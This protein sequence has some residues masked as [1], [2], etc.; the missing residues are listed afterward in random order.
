MEFLLPY[1]PTFL[2]VLLRTGIVLSLLPVLGS[3]SLPSSFKIGLAVAFA[4]VLTPVVQFDVTRQEIPFLVMREALFGIVLGSTARLT[5]LAVDMAGQ[6]ISSAM[7]LSIATVFNPEIGQ[8]TEVARFF[9]MIAILVFLSTDAHHDLIAVFARSYEIT[10]SH[11]LSVRRLIES[12]LFSG[13][14]LFG[15]ALKL[16]APVVVSMLIVNLLLGFLYKIAPQMNVFFVG[17]PVY[18]FVGF[19][20]M[21]MSLPV[22]VNVLGAQF[23]TL[24]ASLMKL[25]SEVGR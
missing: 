2:F 23:G 19:T 13:A 9:G 22:F 4:C 8:S 21:I 1:I 15:F 17:Y 5:F 6:M 18:L 14:S 24:G 7:G 12:A 20:V 25:I 11:E 3:T 10:P 16:S